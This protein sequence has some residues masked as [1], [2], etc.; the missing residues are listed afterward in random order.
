MPSQEGIR[1]FPVRVHRLLIDA[2]HVF[3]SQ[4]AALQRVPECSQGLDTP[5]MSTKCI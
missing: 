4:T 3:P 5:V 1:I 2:L